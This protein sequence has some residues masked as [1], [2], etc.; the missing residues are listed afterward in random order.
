[1]PSSITNWLDSP[2]RNHVTLSNTKPH[3]EMTVEREQS[4]WA[5]MS[6]DEFAAFEIAGGQKL[7][8]IG[9]VWWRRVRPFFY[10]PLL[11]Y[12]QLI[13][14]KLRRPPLSRFG[15]IQYVVPA[16]QHANSTL[17]L[18]LFESPET[19]SLDALTQTGRRR[20]RRA[21][22]VFNVRPIVDVD[23]FISAAHPVYLSFY[24]RTKYGYK[25]DRIERP[26]FAAWAKN[27]FLS[28]K[29]RVFGA[30]QGNDLKSVSIS[31]A[32]EDVAYLATFFSATEALSDFVSDLILH[33]VREQI[34][35]NADISFIF[36]AMGSRPR[37]LD[38]FYLL[39]GA[40]LIRKRAQ[41][42]INPLAL[43]SLK[44]F[45]KEKYAMLR[46]SI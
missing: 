37:G 8:K 42:R 30:Y 23:D 11:P 32:V 10:R 25:N 19:Y 5:S 24:S 4:N 9:D 15:G 29:V 43:A 36:A 13:P 26:K 3:P 7:Q 34:A 45:N 44:I 16:G 28:P 12:R 27:L 6:V 40:H 39:R 35:A 17:D 31:Y 18:L 41:L 46:T 33:S 14:D 20:V 2:A 1:M 21:L 22:K 38:E